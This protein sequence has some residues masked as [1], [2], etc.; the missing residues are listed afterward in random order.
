MELPYDFIFLI[1]I[2]IDAVIRKNI[3]SLQHDEQTTI[4][5]TADNTPVD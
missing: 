4:T 2:T 3:V 5:I 1:K